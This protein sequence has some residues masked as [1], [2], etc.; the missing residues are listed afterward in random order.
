MQAIINGALA[1]TRIAADVPKSDYGIATGI[2]IGAQVIQTAAQVATIQS[3]KFA[4]GGLLVGAS[5][6][7]G[8]IKTSVGGQSVE[9]EGGE[10]VINKVSTAKHSALLSAINQDGGGVPIPSPTGLR[11]FQNGGVLG[12]GS[13]LRGI[14]DEITEGV[15]NAIGSIKVVNVASETATVANRVNQIKNISTF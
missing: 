11:K 14:K 10:A 7:N 6:A 8:G 2:L 15:I 12:S 9:F 1:I 5:H 4:K 13:D 3:Q